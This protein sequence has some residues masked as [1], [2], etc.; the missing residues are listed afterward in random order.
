[1]DMLRSKPGMD[2][3]ILEAQFNASPE[4]IYQAWTD[5]DDLAKW[6]GAS[7][8]KVSRAELDTRPGGTWRIRFDSGASEAGWLEGEYIELDPFSRIVFSWRHMQPVPDS[9]PIASPES[10]V[11]IELSGDET[12]TTLALRHEGISSDSARQNV[13]SGW[14]SSL[15]RLMGSL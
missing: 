6:F 4:R 8:D 2:P 15:E 7:P 14:V 12:L 9:D 11:T 5:P 3:V 10:K 1:M 13:G